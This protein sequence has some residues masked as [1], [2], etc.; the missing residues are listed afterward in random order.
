[1]RIAAVE[2]QLARLERLREPIIFL[3]LE[4][5]SEGT[6]RQCTRPSSV[7]GLCVHALRVEGGKRARTVGHH[8][9]TDDMPVVV[10]GDLNVEASWLNVPCQPSSVIERFLSGLVCYH[11]Q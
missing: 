10:V 2:A 7:A 9:A 4:R 5:P 1:M 11:R 8:A 3:R 6:F